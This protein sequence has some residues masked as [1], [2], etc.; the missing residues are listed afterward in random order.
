MMLV[1]A[2]NAHAI[3]WPSQVLTRDCSSKDWVRDPESSIPLEVVKDDHGRIYVRAQVRHFSL[4]GFLKKDLDAGNQMYQMEPIS[5]WESRKHQ[6]LIK[7]CTPDDVTIHAYAMP[8]S[9]WNAAL[10]S[11]KLGVGAEGLG[12]NAEADGRAGKEA[13]PATSLPQMVPIP[14]DYSHWF[15]IP[16][17][18]TGVRSSRKA[19][20]AIVTES[21]DERDGQRL[22]YDV[23]AVALPTMTLNWCVPVAFGVLL[24]PLTRLCQ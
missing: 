3:V 9:Q 16:R 2:A 21:N 22:R 18:G 24:S 14:S 23:E 15:E 11:F 6:S 7:N 19:V 17:V 20:V 8:M 13:N 10:E 12:V 1:L 4:W 5:W